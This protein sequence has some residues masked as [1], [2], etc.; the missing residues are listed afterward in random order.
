MSPFDSIGNT[1][2]LV[3]R[4]RT[5]S[6]ILTLKSAMVPREN[7]QVL[8]LCKFTEIE[9]RA[10]APR[11]KLKRYLSF[12]GPAVLADTAARSLAKHPPCAMPNLR[13]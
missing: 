11:T 8:D 10:I 12:S 7:I 6:R 5:M 13:K 2:V 4:I 9:D 1:R 3:N